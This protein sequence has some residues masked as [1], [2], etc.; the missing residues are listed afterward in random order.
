MPKIKLSSKTRLNV[1][2][3]RVNSMI[4]NLPQINPGQ[5]KKAIGKDYL[6]QPFIVKHNKLYANIANLNDLNKVNQLVT[7]LLMQTKLEITIDRPAR[8]TINW[9]FKTLKFH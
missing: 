1:P 5:L 7:R 3:G 9:R 8:L 6:P 2:R 4:F